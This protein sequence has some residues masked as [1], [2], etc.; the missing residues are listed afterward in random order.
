MF[1][2]LLALFFCFNLNAQQVESPRVA[3]ID[4]HDFVLDETLQHL[5][6]QY[7]Y[8]MTEEEVNQE[9][10]R[11]ITQDGGDL[12]RKMNEIHVEFRKHTNISSSFTFSLYGWLTYKLS[13]IFDDAITYPIKEETQP[14]SSDYVAIAKK[15]N[16][17]WIINL[18][19]IEI[20]SKSD[21]LQGFVSFELWN[22]NTN[23]VILETQL[24][25]EDTNH[26]FELSCDQ[27]S[28]SCI[29]NNG[30]SYIT[31]E[32]LRSM[33]SAEKYWR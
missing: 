18:K 9:L 27:G 19:K 4:T 8:T 7:E 24:E 30:A 21:G 10:A 17:N 6:Q 3:I 5:Y 16:V 31:Q 22:L 25:I 32:V 11:L 20:L 26:G 12:A 15:Y 1:R 28:V 2:V 13:G 14:T 29:M 23:Q 33:F